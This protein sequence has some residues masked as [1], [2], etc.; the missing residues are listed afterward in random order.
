VNPA[1]AVG[2]RD[3]ADLS[4]FRGGVPEARFQMET[5]E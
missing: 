1:G 4:P 5:V 2:A 3:T